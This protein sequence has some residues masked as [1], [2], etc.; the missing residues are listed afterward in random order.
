MLTCFTDTDRPGV[1]TSWRQRT[2]RPLPD[3]LAVSNG[4]TGTELPCGPSGDMPGTHRAALT[5]EL[6][7]SVDR[8]VFV[9]W[10]SAR[11]PQE[12]P[13]GQRRESIR[14]PLYWRSLV[15]VLRRFGTEPRPGIDCQNRRGFPGI[16]R[17][18]V[19]IPVRQQDKNFAFGFGSTQS[20]D[21]QGKTVSDGCA[22][23]SCRDLELITRPFKSRT[24]LGTSRARTISTW[25]EVIQTLARWFE[26]CSPAFGFFVQGEASCAEHRRARGEVGTGEARSI[27]AGFARPVAGVRFVE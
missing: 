21:S 15:K 10:A 11:E 12:F 25:A 5:D 4:S 9:A 8:L 2:K 14:P 6:D 19:V 16:D 13:P 7:V 3:N 23:S 20:I 1:I 27:Q 18:R 17:S 22:R 24:G 26:A